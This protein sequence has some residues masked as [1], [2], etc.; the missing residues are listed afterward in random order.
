LAIEKAKAAQLTRRDARRSSSVGRDLRANISLA[1]VLD[2]MSAT[3]PDDDP[4][5]VLEVISSGTP[6][7]EISVREQR[8]F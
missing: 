8:R 7:A 3:V 4:R 5:S 1:S 2:P 6:F